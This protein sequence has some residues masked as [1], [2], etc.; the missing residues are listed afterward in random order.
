MTFSCPKF[1]AKI[2]KTRKNLNFGLLSFFRFLKTTKTQVFS[3]PFSNPGC[4]REIAQCGCK[5]RYVSKFTAA[6]RGSPCDSTTFLQSIAAGSTYSSELSISLQMN[7]GILLSV[8]GDVHGNSGEWKRYA[9]IES[10]HQ[11]FSMK[12]WK[13]GVSSYICQLQQQGMSIFNLIHTL[14]TLSYSL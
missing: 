14:S 10:N 3:K 12:K 7:D 1:D 11:R 4:G 2:K 8:G 13:D 5:I 9:I 6:S